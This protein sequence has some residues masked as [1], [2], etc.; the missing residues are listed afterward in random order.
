MPMKKVFSFQS[1]LL[2]LL[3][4][5][6][7]PIP[8]F[9]EGST[10]DGYDISFKM[11]GLQ[12]G[13]TCLIA[14]YLGAKQY[15]RD[16]IIAEAKGVCHYKGDDDIEGGIFLFVMPGNKYFEFILVESSFTLEGTTKDPVNTMKVKG[17]VENEAFF[18]YLQKVQGL[19]KERNVI[20]EK[21]KSP[22]T[23]A[24]EKEK[25]KKRMSE[26]D[27][28][29][30]SFKDQFMEDHPDLFVTKIFRASTEP[31]VPSFEGEGIND[32]LIATKRLQY[33]REH[34]WDNV[35]LSDDRLLRTPVIERRL[36]DLLE[37]YTVQ[38]PDSLVKTAK[39]TMDKVEAGK[40]DEVFRYFVITITNKYAGDKRMCFDKVYVFMAGEYYVSG[41]AF[42]TDST[43]MVKIKD[44]YYKMKYNTCQSRAANLLMRDVD[45]NMKQLYNVD[46][47]YTIVYF[48]AYDCGHCKKVTP[49]MK[50]F[51]NDYKDLGVKV[52]SVSTKKETDKW[53]EAIEEKGIQEFINVEDPEHLSNFRIFYDIYSTPVI[54]VLDKDKNI[55]AKRLDVLSL[56]KFLNHMMGVDIPIP[57]G[58]EPDP[59]QAAPEN[60]K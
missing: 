54:Y 24:E 19:Q 11:D 28:E 39:M 3:M 21:L 41:K 5:A 22:K 48:W 47:P 35:D 1:L 57:E 56:R 36:K 46:A 31:E 51:Y 26:V 49:K 9:G 8:A 45:G 59:Q 53:K 10:P 33:Y 13:D 50:D 37:R 43:Q 20:Q 7:T 40:S 42:W 29:A 14:Y 30:L 27:N 52:F 32:T 25:L 12:E 58:L 38:E 4:L 18:G 55:V 17:S 34:Y 6:I 60:P 23:S 15:I 44:R 16:T 2:T